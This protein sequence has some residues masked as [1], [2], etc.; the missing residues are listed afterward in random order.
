MLLHRGQNLLEV[1]VGDRREIR[2]VF[3][4][5]RNEKCTTAD[6]VSSLKSPAGS[7][8]FSPV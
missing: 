7:I 5:F 4:L 3:S 2:I 1:V 6:P 8:I